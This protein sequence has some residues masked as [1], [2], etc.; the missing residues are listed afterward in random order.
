MSATHS[1]ERDD[2]LLIRYLLGS[3]S[4]DETERLDE[5]SLADNRFAADLHAVEHDLVDAYACGALDE[6]T[7][8]RFELHYLSSPQGRAKVAFARALM[9]Y[10][11]S[12]GPALGRDAGVRKPGAARGLLQLEPGRGSHWPSRCSRLSV[13]RK[14]AAET[15]AG[16]RTRR[17]RTAPAATGGRAAAR[18]SGNCR[19]GARAGSLAPI[20]RPAPGSDA[21]GCVVSCFCRPRAAQPSFRRCRSPADPAC[22]L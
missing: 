10:A 22:S 14:R 6:E 11:R 18:A 17:S 15:P 1:H 13:L 16:R 8:R 7:L 19:N 21:A 5:L 4:E 12:G 2:Q 9:R 20:P 3:L